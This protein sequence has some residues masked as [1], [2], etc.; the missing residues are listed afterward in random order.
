MELDATGKG[1][2][3]PS[4]EEMDRRRERKLCFEC[5]LPGHQAASYRKNQAKKPWKRTKQL[6]AT[7]RGAYDLTGGEPEPVAKDLCIADTQRGRRK[8]LI[9]LIQ[10]LPRIIEINE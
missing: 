10:L 6:K 4:K 7:G 2:P 9:R 5:G 3:K 8:K 1:K